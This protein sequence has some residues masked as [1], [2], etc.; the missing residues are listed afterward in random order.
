M[1]KLC[2]EY[3]EE[4]EYNEKSLF[5]AWN[6][7]NLSSEH[8]LTDLDYRYSNTVNGSDASVKSSSNSAPSD[9]SGSAGQNRSQGQKQRSRSSSYV[10]L[11]PFP[12]NISDFQL[13]DRVDALDHKG[14]WY[15]G[16]VVEVLSFYT[17]PPAR[18]PN[19]NPHN[20][21]YFNNNHAHSN[22]P[23]SSKKLAKEKELQDQMDAMRVGE[24]ETFLRVHFDNFSQIWDEWYDIN[25]FNKSKLF[26]LFSLTPTHCLPPVLPCSV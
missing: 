10:G 5:N 25:E 17:P 24:T 6:L 1:D 12:K 2:Y 18:K 7:S 14:Q 3:T 8:L 15:S 9:K 19:S 26:L 22:Y 23:Q 13:F 11:R 20:L 16:S 21:N 4:L